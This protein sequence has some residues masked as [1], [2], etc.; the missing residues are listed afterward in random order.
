M[1]NSS[2]PQEADKKN[3]DEEQEMKK[4][5]EALSKLSEENLKNLSE[6][7]QKKLLESYDKILKEVDVEEEL[8]KLEAEMKEYEEKKNKKK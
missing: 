5:K 2:N 7:E 4:L 8:D 6:E 3:I 1:N